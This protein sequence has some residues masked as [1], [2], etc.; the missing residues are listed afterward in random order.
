VE[1]YRGYS[2]QESKLLGHKRKYKGIMGTVRKKK[3][4]RRLKQLDAKGQYQWNVMEFR[5]IR[6][7]LVEPSPNGNALNRIGW[8]PMLYSDP[9]YRTNFNG[10]FSLSSLQPRTTTTFHKNDNNYC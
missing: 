3:L 6:G 5:V 1:A 7:I 2:L 10:P 9:E 8:N 4:L